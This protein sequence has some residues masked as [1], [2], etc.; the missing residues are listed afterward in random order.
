MHHTHTHTHTHT[1]AHT[2]AARHLT[3]WEVACG[4]LVAP[5]RL[6]IKLTALETVTKCAPLRRNDLR[7]QREIDNVPCDTQT[8]SERVRESVCVRESEREPDTQRDRERES[9]PVF[10]S[11]STLTKPL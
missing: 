10:H 3:E 7:W 8:E 6:R 4:V 1:Q 2:P 9:A 5:R 11:R